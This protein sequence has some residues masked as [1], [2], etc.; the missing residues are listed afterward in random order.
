MT[1]QRKWSIFLS[2]RLKKH[3]PPTKMVDFVIPELEKARPSNENGRI[4]APRDWKSTTLLRKR[5]IFSPDGGQNLSRKCHK[6]SVDFLATK[7]LISFSF[8]ICR[9]W[10]RKPVG[11][12]RGRPSLEKTIKITTVQ[13]KWSI[14]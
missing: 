8:A 14:F 4:F 1:L 7:T 10:F 3:E 9:S 5:S 6:N 11:V 12:S 13:R 2:K